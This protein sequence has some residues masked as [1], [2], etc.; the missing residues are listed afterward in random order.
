V[1]PS[2]SFISPFFPSFPLDSQTN[3]CAAPPTAR[4]SNQPK[5]SRLGSFKLICREPVT[6]QQQQQQ[7]HISVQVRVCL[8]LA[9]ISAPT[10]P[11][12]EEITKDKDKSK[13]KR[14]TAVRGT[15]SAT[16]KHQHQ[17]SI[18]VATEVTGSLVSA[19]SSTYYCKIP[20]LDDR[21]PV[22]ITA[23][24]IIRSSFLLAI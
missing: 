17:L 10:T 21:L 22:I 12:E 13:E 23:S 2:Y 1:Y 11:G 19:S 9:T 7:Q 5:P 3:L 8:L 15:V 14:R 24:C 6:K 16:R 4:H 20:L 18:L